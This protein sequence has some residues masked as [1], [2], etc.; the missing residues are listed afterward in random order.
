[1]PEQVFADTRA[2]KAFGLI[3]AL[4]MI[5]AI[6]PSTLEGQGPDTNLLA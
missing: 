6:A 3:V 1:M 4:D 2:D 5:N